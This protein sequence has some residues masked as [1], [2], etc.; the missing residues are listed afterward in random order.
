LIGQQHLGRCA[1]KA[2]PVF[3]DQA[4]WIGLQFTHNRR[5]GLAKRVEGPTA[6]K[7]DRHQGPHRFVLVQAVTDF[8]LRVSQPHM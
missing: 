5:K 6:L 4:R 1:F 7:P 3:A 8:R 2:V